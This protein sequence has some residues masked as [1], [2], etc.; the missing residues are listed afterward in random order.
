MTSAIQALSRSGAVSVRRARETL[1]AGVVSLTQVFGD[2]GDR[3][4]GLRHD[5]YSPLTELR[6]ERP[7]SLRHDS[8][9]PPQPGS[10][11]YE[12]WDTACA[13]AS[14]AGTTVTA[15]RDADTDT[16]SCSG[17]GVAFAMTGGT[18][19]CVQGF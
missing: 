11:L 7:S 13:H 2:L 8:Q 14:G 3:L 10:S 16:G 4:P 19:R 17:P 18:F 9:L 1:L 15:T 5:P 12:G 6:I